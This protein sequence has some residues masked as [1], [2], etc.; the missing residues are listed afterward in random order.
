METAVI[1]I[2][3]CMSFIKKHR[4]FLVSGCV[5]GS[6]EEV[7]N[8]QHNYLQ[9][10]NI[11]KCLKILHNCFDEDS[12]AASAPPPPPS[13]AAMQQLS[14]GHAAA[15]PNGRQ[16]SRSP[17]PG[18]KRLKEEG[19]NNSNGTDDVIKSIP[20]Q[21]S[22]LHYGFFCNQK[23]SKNETTRPLLVVVSL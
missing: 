5:T 21:E 15:T 9:L 20:Q 23:R 10:E 1:F 19:A 6:D 18:L 13:A 3:D 22:V 14:N 4:N 2:S 17:P 12:A 16:K 7:A 11:L 8:M